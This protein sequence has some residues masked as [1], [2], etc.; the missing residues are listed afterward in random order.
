MRE[1]CA[2]ILAPVCT[3]VR[4]AFA[5]SECAAFPFHVVVC[6]RFGDGDTCTTSPASPPAHS[7]TAT[8]ALAMCPRARSVLLC[9]RG[10]PLSTPSL[11]CSLRALTSRSV[12]GA[13]SLGLD[14]RLQRK[15]G[16]YGVPLTG[17]CVAQAFTS[18]RCATRPH[19]VSCPSRLSS[20]VD[21]FVFPGVWPMCP[22]GVLRL[23]ASPVFF[24]SAVHSST[25]RHAFTYTPSTHVAHAGTG[26]RAAPCLLPESVRRG[27]GVA[28]CFHVLPPRLSFSVCGVACVSVSALATTFSCRR[29]CPPCLPREGV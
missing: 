28:R 11:L 4:E 9:S 23:A 17:G 13:T 27:A 3:H 10:C 26:A 19:G 14:A 22:H 25:L 6:V 20:V 24:P 5:K 15:R 7:T 1:S 16:T 21:R 8:A 29:V 2:R 12:K 18:S